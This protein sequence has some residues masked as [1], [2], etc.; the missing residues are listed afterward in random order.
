[1]FKAFTRVHGVHPKVV[2]FPVFIAKL[3]VVHTFVRKLITEWRRLEL[4]FEGRTFVVAVSGGAD[5]VSLLLALAELHRTKKLGNRFIAAHFN[6]KLRGEESEID[7]EFVKHVA[8]TLNIELA[9]GHAHLPDAGNLEQNARNARYDFLTKISEST[10]AQG[11]ITAHTQNDQAETFLM[12]LIRGAGPDGLGGI[13]PIRSMSPETP[14][15]SKTPGANGAFGTPER[16]ETD[17]PEES[18]TGASP[19]LPFEPVPFLLIRPLLTWARRHD[20][21]GFCHDREVEYRYDSMNEDLSFTR[22]RIRRLL[23]PMLEEFN[24]KIVETLAHTASLMRSET[25]AERPVSG[26]ADLDLTELKKLE[27]GDLYDALRRWLKEKRGNTRSLSL[28]HIE[29]IERLALSRKSG[30]MVELP[31][32]KAVVK[33]AGMLV[34]EDLKVEK[35]SSDG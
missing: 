21:E 2:Q 5:S 11:I 16:T 23:L 33:R 15:T 7:A 27:K 4:P 24:P 35:R 9:V 29:A 32:G 10:E 30:R 3:F 19:L 31:G 18:R 20:T 1:M 8:G 14:E 25:A 6:H 28:K 34:Y 22:V 26:A 17:A 13:K 12:N